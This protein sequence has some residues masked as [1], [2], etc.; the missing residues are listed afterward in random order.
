MFCNV[1]RLPEC[2]ENTFLCR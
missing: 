1:S 2:A